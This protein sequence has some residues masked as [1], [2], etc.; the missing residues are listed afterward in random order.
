MTNGHRLMI[1]VLYLFCNSYSQPAASQEI[2]DA[3]IQQ[4]R[5]HLL[6]TKVL[7]KEPGRYIGWSSVCLRKNGELV[8]VFSGDR[9]EHVCP[10]GKVQMIKSTDM[11]ETWTAPVTIC[12][13][14]LDDRDAGILEL[15]NSDLLVTWF[16]S[17]AYIREIQDRAKLVPGTPRFYW[18]LH[19]EKI[20]PE[21]K[22]EWL[23]HFTARSTDG[24]KTWEK[25]VRTLGSANHGPLL[26]QDGRLL[27]VGRYWS[28]DGAASITGE[29]KQTVSVE[30]SRDNGRSWQH[31]V[32]LLPTPPE[33]IEQFHEPFAVET[34]DGRIVAQFRFHADPESGK[35]NRDESKCMLH[36]AESAD[37]GRTW[38]QMTPTLIQ[39]YP[40]HLIRL[41]DGKLLTVY[42]RRMPAYGEYAC[43]SDDQGRTWDVANE[44]KL[45][46]HYNGD[47]GYPASVELP[48][49]DILTVYYQAEKEGEKTCLMGTCWRVRE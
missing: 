6:W 18:A 1:A 34:N 42:G 49:G 21:T 37:G 14:P 27:L 16:T 33:H 20:T 15:P 36:Q 3:P 43:L 8:A 32:D 38:T 2:H 11:G 30:E 44:I 29:G 22:K 7:C 45:A 48:N 26:L 31:V 19:D 9:D 13:T 10:W 35:K 39:G 46:G 4:K 12:N 24:G 47:L 25:P 17:V 5:G 23:G 41:K 28:G 40:P